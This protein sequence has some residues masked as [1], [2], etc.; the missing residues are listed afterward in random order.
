MWLNHGGVAAP[1]AACLPANLPCPPAPPAPLQPAGFQYIL[2]YSTHA[3]DVAALALSTKLKLAAVADEGGSV[4]VIDL[5]GPSRLF[6][7]PAPLGGGVPARQL[8]FGSH[9]VPAA[10]G[11]KGEAAEGDMEK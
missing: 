3:A 1:N 9:V 8:A 10:A 2:R 7:V 6:A 11:A 5:M 4:S